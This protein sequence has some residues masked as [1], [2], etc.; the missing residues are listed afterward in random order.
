MMEKLKDLAVIESQPR[1]ESNRMF[2][3]LAPPKIN[4]QKKA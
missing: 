4:P 3:M 2:L 1:L